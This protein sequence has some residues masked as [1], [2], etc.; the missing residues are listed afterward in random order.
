M[1][2]DWARFDYY[3]PRIKRLGYYI[4]EFRDRDLSM[5]RGHN[6]HPWTR[7]VDSELITQLCLYRRTPYILPNLVALRWT[8]WDVA[9]LRHLPMFL[10]PSLKFLS[11]AFWKDTFAKDSNLPNELYY[12]TSEILQS[13]ATLCPSLTQL[14]MVLQQE[15][16]VIDAST[17]F[18]FS[19]KRLEGFAV[20]SRT[21]SKD[22]ILYLS[23]QETLKRVYL[24]IDE[25]TANDLSFLT[26]SSP[27]RYPFPSLDTLTMDT[28]TLSS[29]TELIK[30]MGQ[31]RL[32]LI[33]FEYTSR[34][35][36]IDLH[37]L[38]VA[39]WS[40]CSKT[41]LQHL[42]VQTV[43][44]REYGLH[45]DYHAFTINLIHPMMDFPN[46]TAFI[47]GV[48]LI[49]CM[50]DVELCHIARCWRNLRDLRLLDGWGWSR[51]SEITFAALA[52]LAWACP[53]LESLSIAV[54]ATIDNVSLCT[55]QHDFKPNKALRNF[56]AMDSIMGDPVLFARCVHAFA[57]TTLEVR[58]TGWCEQDEDNMEILPDQDPV[59]FF[60]AVNE[61]IWEM[62]S[63]GSGKLNK[64]SLEDWG[65][66][67]LLSGPAADL[68]HR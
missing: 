19:C 56:D 42:C 9:Y 54:N 36:S 5:W 26:S 3:A 61:F 23:M 60:M 53:R 31:C 34:A 1:K 6:Y 8:K 18:L 11:I 13:L 46:I 68:T 2:S 58:G 4:A 64:T 48:P 16:E 67:I 30:M 62:R 7:P 14:E 38:F 55:G 25:E 43:V 28:T 63:N 47:I 66:S 20:S 51:P 21:W 49:G 17:A 32:R 33:E 65:E 41:T 39:L 27:L 57:P 35:D 50:G 52:F 22:V 44:T 40:H 29:C 37:H 59:G 24:T 15:A 10:G 45:T 12:H